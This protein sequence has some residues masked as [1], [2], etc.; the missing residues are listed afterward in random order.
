MWNTRV[1]CAAILAL[2]PLLLSGCV[3]FPA[4]VASP[5]T[6]IVLI[7]HAERDP[8]ADPP[9]L[10][11]GARRAEALRDALCDSGVS[12]VYCTD[13]LRNRQT[14]APLCEKLGIEPVLIDPRTYSDVA[15]AAE[16]LIDRMLKDHPGRVVL[17]CGNSG[18]APNVGITTAIYNR[19]GGLG[20]GPD[21]YGQLYMI[22]VFGDGVRSVRRYGI[23]RLRYG[24][25]SSMP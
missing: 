9:L 7:R 4:I 13:L 11:E 25:P 12:A 5:E 22:D 18:H 20:I 23:A 14:V 1:R 8:G 24:E 10:P 15:A 19:L 21:G 17:F 16:A 2:I 3:T 6:T